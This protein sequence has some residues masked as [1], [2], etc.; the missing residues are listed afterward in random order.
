LGRRN[1]RLATTEHLPNS[2]DSRTTTETQDEFR[3]TPATGTLGALVAAA[4]KRAASLRTARFDLERKAA[5]SPSAPSLKAA[6]RRSDLALIAEI[7]RASPSKGSINRGIDPVA[8]AKAY[9]SGGAAAV[10]V[11][12]ESESFGGS[13]DDL[14]LV[15]AA[16]AIPTLKKDFNVDELQLLE[17]RANGASAALLIARALPAHRFKE[18][19]NFARAIGLE[20]LAE[21]RDLRELE[22][23]IDAL[24]E[25]IGVNNRNLETLNIEAGT[26]DTIIPRI[27]AELI[28]VAESGYSN[29]EEIAQVAAVG[30]DAVL[31]GSFLSASENPASAVKALTGI[32]RVARV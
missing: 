30:T 12:T 25:I 17:A 9:A 16:V 32:R 18:L 11:L 1:F 15:A 23:A 6:L 24:C 22:T 13:I 3:W 4:E 28:A 20:I 8:Q 10:S 5:A 7:K 14:R 31:I 21:V 19:A 29:R 27:P 2:K 26:A